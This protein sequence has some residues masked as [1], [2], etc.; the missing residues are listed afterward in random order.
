MHKGLQ[1]RLLRL[2]MAIAIGELVGLWL[3]THPEIPCLGPVVGPR[4]LQI[5]GAAAKALASEQEAL[6]RES[7]RLLPGLYETR[8]PLYRLHAAA[9]GT[10]MDGRAGRRDLGVVL[11][12]YR[13]IK[14]ERP[15]EVE[16]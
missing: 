8:V 16:S 12:A 4:L 15:V 5:A 3:A 13:S 7:D 9:Q 14:E 2:T 10:V 6:S 11:A 1:T